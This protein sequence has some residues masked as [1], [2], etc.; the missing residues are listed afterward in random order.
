[1]SSL[2][3]KQPI[4]LYHQLEM[5]LRHRINSSEFKVGD[6]LPSEE[7]LGKEYQV[8]RITVRQALAK[9]KDD[10]IIRRMPGK[11]T[12]VAKKDPGTTIHKFDGSIEDAIFR[13]FGPNYEARL[14]SS[15]PTDVVES[16]SDALQLGMDEKVW[17]IVRIRL[18]DG[19]PMGYFT[20]FLPMDIGQQI[21]SEDIETRPILNT[22]ETRLGFDLA[23]AEQHID[24]TIADTKLAEILDINI[25]D[26]LLRLIRTTF[27]KDGRP[28]NHAVV[29]IRSDN[30]S[31]KV[32]LKRSHTSQ[33]E[34]KGWSVE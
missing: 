7:V 6:P 23:V 34:G 28:V 14:I 10:E 29:L 20:N 30:Y 22:L 3:K 31:F 27:D 15:A 11:G 2:S 26:P 17:E 18:G 19:S 9:L 16:V 4:P 13:G 32:R 24:A 1:M 25:G 12:F 21:S 8:S 5:N 33:N